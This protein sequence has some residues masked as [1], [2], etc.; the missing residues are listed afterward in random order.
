M[1]P[2]APAGTIGGVTRYLKEK[3]G[4]AIQTYLI[5]R[6]RERAEVLRRDGARSPPR[7]AVLIDG[8]GIAIRETARSYFT[9]VPIRPRRRGERRSLR[10]FSPGVISPPRVPRFQSRALDAFQLRF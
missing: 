7:A 8:I 6:D 2:R 4:D 3:R 5:D 1:P 9:L 10:T